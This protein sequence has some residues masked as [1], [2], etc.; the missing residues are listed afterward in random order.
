MIEELLNEEISL[1]DIVQYIKKNLW[2]IG[3]CVFFAG[4]IGVISAL[5]VDKEIYRATSSVIMSKEA[6]RIFYD[7]QYTKSD[8]DLY[9]QVGNTY[10]EIAESNA[11]IDGAIE[12]LNHSD[13]M[14]KSYTRDELKKLVDADYLS[15]TLVIKLI[16]AS[17]DEEDDVAAIAN[18]YTESF[19]AM[20]NTYLPV[21][22]LQV[23]DKAEF[24][25]EPIKVSI[26]RQG[27]MGSIIVGMIAG[28]SVF[29]RLLIDKC[30]VQKPEQIEGLLGIEVLVH[31]KE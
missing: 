17:E 2:F 12:L 19:I 30:R 5:V 7:D 23:L 18:A 26:V 3:L 24:P 29:L 20:A 4:F 1:L 9:Q 22:A 16:A 13:E 27:L 11:V 28:G 14:E 21:S 15:G 10:I 6:A 25:N 31:F 8:I